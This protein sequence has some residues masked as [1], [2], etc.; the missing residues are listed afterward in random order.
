MKVLHVAPLWFPIAV[1]AAGGRETLVAALSRAQEKLGCQTTVLG[2]GDSRV[3]GGLLPVMPR[4]LFEM[5]GEKEAWEATYYEQHQLLV[6]LEHAAE[7]DVIHSHAGWYAFALSGVPGIGGRVLHTHHTPV[8]PDLEWFVRQHP[9]FWYSAVSD[10]LARR[11][12]A[13]GARRCAVVH[14]GIDVSAFEF[15][16][17]GG[18]GLVFIGRLERSKGPDLSIQV[19]RELGLP[20]TI[21]GPI[22][23]HDYY[24]SAIKPFLNEQIRHVGVVNHEGRNKLFGQAGCAVLPFRGQEGFPM[25][26]IEAMACGTPVVSLTNGPIP[27][28]IENGL[29][30]YI[31]ADETALAGLARQAMKLDRRAIRE[32]VQSR[33]DMSIIARQYLDLYQRIVDS[34]T[35]T[36]S[37]RSPSAAARRPAATR[38]T[39]SRRVRRA[40]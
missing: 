15:H 37:R 21:A 26:T 40:K 18:E 22:I 9:D 20:L 30:G 39:P 31:T 13:Q 38:P 10:F 29:T 14:N 27:E 34:K 2:S 25:V 16:P 19:A 4:N 36:G 32:L 5:M 7:F 24:Q 28:I 11:F 6:A 8:W 12:R 35:K 3:A 17:R 23:D 1:D 33:W